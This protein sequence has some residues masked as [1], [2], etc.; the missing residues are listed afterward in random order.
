MISERLGS[1]PG[2]SLIPEVVP[3]S[4]MSPTTDSISTREKA[5]PFSEPGTS[6]P[7]RNSATR[8]MVSQVPDDT[9]TRVNPVRL[10]SFARGANVDE[11]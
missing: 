8:A 10:M 3:A 11:T 5:W 9:T 4:M 7:R 2:M 1:I 6:R